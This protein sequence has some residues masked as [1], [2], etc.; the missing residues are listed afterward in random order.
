[1]SLELVGQEKNVSTKKDPLQ[2][3]AE[4]IEFLNKKARRN[5]RPT[6]VNL[7]FVLKRFNEG[8]TVQ[9]CKSVVALMCRKWLGNEKMVDYLRPATLFNCTN[10]NQYVG[11]I[12]DE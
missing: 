9:D 1:M 10:F 7:D 2:E 4:V 11:L 5:Y 6:K 3:A 12:V 8:Y